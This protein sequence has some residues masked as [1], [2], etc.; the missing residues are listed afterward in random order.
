M[1]LI[2]ELEQQRKE[3]EKYTWREEII[4]F[5]IVIY[6]NKYIFGYSLTRGR[7]YPP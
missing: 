6:I 1:S 4:Y 2:S 3:E 7:R 5:I